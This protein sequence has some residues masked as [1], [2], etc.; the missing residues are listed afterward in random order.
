MLAMM[1]KLLHW[2]AI[3]D[4]SD[5]AIISKSTEGYITSWNRGAERLY[6]YTADEIVGR[7]VSVLMPPER[8]DDFPMILG[9]LLS[10]QKVEHYETKRKT[11]DGRVIDVSLTVSPI[12]DSH[13]NIIGASKIARDVSERVENERRRDEFVSTVSHELK[14][15]ITSQK[16]YGEHFEQL[17]QKNGDKE[18]LPYIKKI[19]AQT[20]KLTKL[21]NDLLELSRMQTGLLKIEYKLFDIDSLVHEIIDDFVPTT[22]H[23]LVCKGSTGQQVSGDRERIGQVLNNLIS[24]AIKYSPRADKVV[25]TSAT[26]DDSVVISIQDFGIGIPKHYHQKIFERFFRVTGI[27]ESTFPGMGIG[28]NLCQ[29]IIANHHGAIRLESELGIGSTFYVSLPVAPETEKGKQ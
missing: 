11:K 27:D 15:P 1:D 19:N 8:E 10:G 14:T 21:V 3:I 4:S 6:G 25:I 16:I 22:T 12:R 24:N 2:A 9:R 29:E 7:P 20:E 28:L 13:G 17:I 5:D 18:Y 23:R 26:R